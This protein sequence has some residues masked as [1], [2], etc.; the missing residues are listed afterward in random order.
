MT[1]TVCPRCLQLREPHKCTHDPD[2]P[3]LRCAGRIGFLGYDQP[4]DTCWRC[5][6]VREGVYVWREGVA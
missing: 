3:C 6:L 5:H 2:A 4:R 1:E